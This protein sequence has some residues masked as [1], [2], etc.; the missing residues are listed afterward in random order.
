M[1]SSAVCVN[2]TA[3]IF[4]L[5]KL[6][7]LIRARAKWKWQIWSI[8][9]RKT[10]FAK[11][12]KHKIKGSSRGMLLIFLT[13][14]GI[15]PWEDFWLR[16]NKQALKTTSENRMNLNWGTKLMTYFW[17]KSRRE[18]LMP[19]FWCDLDSFAAE[20]LFPWFSAAL[21]KDL[22]LSSYQNIANVCIKHNN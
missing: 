19:C 12:R 10:N 15:F 11:H 18:S 4:V 20:V 7:I 8:I 3:V 16:L 1:V 13:A 22:E 14:H 21:W 9:T 17:M 6:R 5:K 2:K